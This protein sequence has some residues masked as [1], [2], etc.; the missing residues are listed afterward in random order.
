MGQRKGSCANSEEEIQGKSSSGKR[1][2][3]CRAPEV[4]SLDTW[5]QERETTPEEKGAGNRRGGGEGREV[6]PFPLLA[7]ILVPIQ[8]LWSLK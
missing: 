2:E 1:Q 7:Q 5:E 4:G 8:N 3:Y 6:S